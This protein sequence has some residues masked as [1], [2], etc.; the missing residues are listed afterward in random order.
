MLLPQLKELLESKYDTYVHTAICTL[1]L[2]LRDFGQVI[3]NGL[4]MVPSIGVDITQEE[5]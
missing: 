2:V 4:N 3:K 1:R 5:R